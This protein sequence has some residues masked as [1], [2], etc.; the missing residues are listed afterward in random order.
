MKT[1]TWTHRLEEWSHPLPANA[2]AT[3]GLAILA[4][5]IVLFVLGGV[6]LSQ[7]PE[8]FDLWVIA[9]GL[10]L[11]AGA[12]V[13]IGRTTGRTGRADRP[14]SYSDHASLAEAP[15]FSSAPADPSVA[16]R[17]A[18]MPNRSWAA[19]DTIAGQYAEA[20]RLR[21]GRS[22]VRRASLSGDL[23]PTQGAGYAYSTDPVRRNYTASP[24]VPAGRRSRSR[25]SVPGR[26]SR[27]SRPPPAPRQGCDRPLGDPPLAGTEPVRGLRHRPGRGSRRRALRSLRSPALLE[28]LRRGAG[29]LPRPPV[30]G[31][32]RGTD[33]HTDRRG[34]A[35]GRDGAYYAPSG[36]R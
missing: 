16:V 3:V 12:I 14:R 10:F 36:D 6:A 13:G 20:A 18:T 33:R 34:A 24:Y 1:D 27:S 15:A 21:A 19:S 25:S 2:L 8:A 22:A 31:M 32:S 30:P 23:D 5:G 4:I 29:G 26:G 9:I 17:R 28:V 7:D 11:L 35:R